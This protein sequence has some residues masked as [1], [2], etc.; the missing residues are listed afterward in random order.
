MSATVTIAPEGELTI[1]TAA[2]RHAALAAGLAEPADRVELDLSGVDELDTAGLQ[3]L[4][5]LARTLRQRGTEV[6]VTAVADEVSAVFDAVGIDPV[7]L[8]SRSTR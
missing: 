4:L 1:A 6:L 3:L 8:T 5:A 7:T 2:E